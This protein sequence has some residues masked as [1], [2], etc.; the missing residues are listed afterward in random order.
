VLVTLFF[1]ILLNA[2]HCK[3]AMLSYERIFGVLS[4]EP[5]LLCLFRQKA[6]LSG[7]ILLP[8]T[9]S[10]LPIV[11]IGAAFWATATIIMC[12]SKTMVELKRAEDKAETDPKAYAD[13]RLRARIVAFSDALET[14]RSH[15]LALSFVLVTST[16]ATVA[17]LRI[18]LGFL[19]DADR[20]GF[21]AVSDSVGLVWGVTFSL[22]LLA[23]CVYPFNRLRAHFSKVASNAHVT[24]SKVLDQW[25]IENR[26][27]LQVPANLQ[28]VLSV[29]LPA[30]VAVVTNL[31][32]T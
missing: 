2:L 18:P 21:K 17:Y 28:L 26:V 31:V 19:A 30:T 24:H 13:T 12:A 7:Y 3:L 23:L 25:L 32:S 8:T 27:L 29:L 6:L 9:F 10:L 14:L 11:S 1:L 22:T 4:R 5:S 16:L 20:R 15:A